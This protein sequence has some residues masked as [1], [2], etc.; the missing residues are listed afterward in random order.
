MNAAKMG[1]I[2]VSVIV[3]I[4]LIAGLASAEGVVLGSGNKP[5]MM[6]INGSTYGQFFAGERE[7]GQEQGGEEGEAQ[8]EEEEPQSD[9]LEGDGLPEGW[10]SD[11]GTNMSWNNSPRYW[12]TSFG[13]WK[14][15]MP[16]YNIPEYWNTNFDTWKQTM[17]W[18]NVPEYWDINP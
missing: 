9:W 12:D 2:L 10:D 8:E 1:T 6:V 16:W 4:S 18:Y 11:F 7:E 17:P 15:T 13:G 3:L 14:Q 5:A